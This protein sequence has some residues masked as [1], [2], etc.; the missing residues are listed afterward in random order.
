MKKPA[1]YEYSFRTFSRVPSEII[2]GSRLDWK[3]FQTDE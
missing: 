1:V 3:K 2:L